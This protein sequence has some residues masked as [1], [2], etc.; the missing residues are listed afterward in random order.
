MAI[1]RVAGELLDAVDVAEGVRLLGVSVSNLADDDG[2][3]LSLDELASEPWDG[4]ADAVD[5]VRA[6]FGDDA[7]GPAATLGKGGLRLKRSGDQQW[8]P[9]EP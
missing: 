1:S 6:R 2:A 5:R 3:Q 4:V 7:V 8:G 9:T